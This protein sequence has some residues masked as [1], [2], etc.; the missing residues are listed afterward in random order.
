M[1]GRRDVPGVPRPGGTRTAAGGGGSSAVTQPRRPHHVPEGVPYDPQHG[2]GRPVWD[3]FGRRTD[4]GPAG[5]W[6]NPPADSVS[7]RL[8]NLRVETIKTA[9]YPGLPPTPERVLAVDFVRTRE[10]EHRGRP[11]LAGHSD[12]GRLNIGHSLDTFEASGTIRLVR[13]LGMGW[14]DES[15]DIELW[16]ETDT[17]VSSLSY[18]VSNAVRIGSPGESV[19]ARDFTPAEREEVRLSLP[20]EGVP[21]GYAALTDADPLP[22]GMPVMVGVDAEWVPGEVLAVKHS[23][24]PHDVKVSTAAPDRFGK[25]I[26]TVPRLGDWLAV[27]PSVL[28]AARTNPEAFEPTVRLLPDGD[29]PLPDGAVP[30]PN[31]GVRRYPPG[32][33]VLLERH[34]EWREVRVVDEVVRYDRETYLNVRF[35]DR[36]PDDRPV[37]TA[38]L[39]VREEVL[40]ALD[41]DGA[42]E[43]LGGELLAWGGDPADAP[44]PAWPPQDE[45]LVPE[46]VVPMTP[47][48]AEAAR[49]AD[50]E[51]RAQDAR[52]RM[53]D[54]AAERDRERRAEYA[55]ERRTDGGASPGNYPRRLPIPDGGSRV[56]NNLRLPIGTAV[57][58][59]S[60]YGWEEKQVV[61]EDDGGPLRVGSLDDSPFHDRLVARNQLAMKSE[62]LRELRLNP[63]EPEVDADAGTDEADMPDD[64][65]AVADATSAESAAD[66][67][68]GT[69]DRRGP[70]PPEDLQ[71]YP[72][73]API[74]S[75]WERVPADLTVPAGT[76]LQ[77]CWGR[78]WKPISV[79]TDGRD[80]PLA[81][82]WVGYGSSWDGHLPRTQLIIERTVIER[83]RGG[84]R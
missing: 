42:A 25:T 84:D 69:S 68:A 79:R 47:A 45:P 18:M 39:A 2:A 76:K 65:D 9:K 80:G 57:F 62:T 50:H 4:G 21:A 77:A 70:S 26:T 52:D 19:T 55:E 64:A 17:P 1:S 13:E 83:L 32:T 6:I 82:H 10:G 46:P 59:V 81:I 14:L 15:P 38:E 60:G 75:G 41:A 58:H 11:H 23:S 71:D 37:R 61:A 36:E 31:L 63:P 28:A 27:R 74:P 12:E 48:E 7:Y 78:S 20:P 67:A 51:A 44:L 3:G 30:L 72:I 22:P 49:R 56:P 5:R 66:P 8:S 35:P 34:G 33:P 53:R 16:V 54:R 40:A 43:R 73:R 24:R 29:L